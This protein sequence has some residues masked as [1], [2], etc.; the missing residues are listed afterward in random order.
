MTIA[1]SSFNSRRIP[2]KFRFKPLLPSKLP[3]VALTMHRV[4]R[5][6]VVVLLDLSQGMSYHTS[7]RRYEVSN[8]NN[9]FSYEELLHLHLLML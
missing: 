6:S 1:I 9:S 4:N 8:N 5:I 3:S 2:V 7:R